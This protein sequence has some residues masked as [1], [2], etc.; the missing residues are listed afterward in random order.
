MADLPPVIAIDGPAAAGKG[1]A[2]RMLAQH[3]GFH[4][5]DS[6]KI[7]RA[8]AHEALARQ[9]APDN[10]DAMQIL[11]EEMAALPADEICA[12]PGL[13]L[14]ET[15]AA[16]SVLAKIP[17]VRAAFLPV[18]RRFRRFPGLVADGRDMGLAVFPDAA[19]KVY[20]TAK[21][22]IRA[23]RRLKELQEKKIHAT[24]AD[25]L[26]DIT[27]RDTQDST[28]TGAPLAVLPDAVV[29]DSSRLGVS[30]VVNKLAALYAGRQPK[31]KSFT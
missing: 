2:A 4:Y 8:A 11:A 6:G 31:E 14:P 26:A 3:L 30:A 27:R 25:V 28:R 19:L 12:R 16:A 20:L 1:A 13:D 5:L 17:A 22:E 7:Y 15:G 10:A 29:V 23:K 24:I 21:P 9:I 18:Q